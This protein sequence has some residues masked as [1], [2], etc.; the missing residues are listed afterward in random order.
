MEG[1]ISHL[2]G[3]AGQPA[4]PS[5]WGMMAESGPVYTDPSF[6]CW[7]VKK[8]HALETGLSFYFV[9]FAPKYFQLSVD[10]K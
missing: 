4:V 2:G 8:S 1:D 7:H 5:T 10:K 6:L 3:L 9:Y